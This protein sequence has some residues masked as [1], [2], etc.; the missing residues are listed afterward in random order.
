MRRGHSPPLHRHGNVLSCLTALKHP[1]FLA[2]YSGERSIGKINQRWTGNYGDQLPTLWSELIDQRKNLNLTQFFFLIIDHPQGDFDGLYSQTLTVR[3]QIIHLYFHCCALQP[4]SLHL[5][6]ILSETK[7]EKT[8]MKNH[9]KHKPA[10]SLHL[11]KNGIKKRNPP[12]FLAKISLI[13][14]DLSETQLWL[15]HP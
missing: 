7:Q 8:L 11:S 1:Q 15:C 14:K 6:N 3:R 5:Y 2:C 13:R 12:A 9:L 4:L 10:E